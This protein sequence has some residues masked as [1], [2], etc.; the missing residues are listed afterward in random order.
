M[1]VIGSW[2]SIVCPPVLRSFYVLKSVYRVAISVLCVYYVF[3][4]QQWQLIFS[5]YWFVESSVYSKIQIIWVRQYSCCAKV[6]VYVWQ[7]SLAL[8]GFFLWRGIGIIVREKYLCWKVYACVRIFNLCLDS[9]FIL[10]Y[11]ILQ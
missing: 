4:W 6:S 10:I 9:I 8:L 11:Y 1:C 3:Y 5:F 7:D 2:I